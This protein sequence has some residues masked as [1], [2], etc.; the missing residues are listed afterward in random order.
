MVWTDGNLVVFN[1]IRT[2]LV[3][4]VCIVGRPN[5]EIVIVGKELRVENVIVKV[6]LLITVFS[7][8]RPVGSFMTPAP[9]LLKNSLI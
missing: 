7:C 3:R 9:A 4:N 1:L 6:T 8:A 5:M 2:D